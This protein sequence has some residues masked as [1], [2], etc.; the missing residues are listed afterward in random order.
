MIIAAFAALFL[1]LWAIF[2]ATLPALR[3]LGRGL[4][5]YAA[6]NT[7]VERVFSGAEKRFRVYVPVVV[8]VVAGV[9]LTAWAGDLFLDLALQVHAKS[10]SLEQTD[11]HIHDWAVTRRS[12]GATRFFVIMTVLGGPVGLAVLITAV[13]AL[14]AVRHRYRWLL[15]LLVTEVGGALLNLG[16]KQYFARSRPDVAEMLRRAHGYSFPSGHAMGSAVAFS[17]LAYLAMRSVR[18]WPLKAAILS[19]ALSMM[20]AVALSRVY[21]G[22]H[23]LSDVAAGVIAGLVWVSSTTIAY[24]TLRRIRILR[25]LRRRSATA[26]AITVP[27]AA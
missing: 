12:G 23:W 16:L 15:Y 24:E 14:L 8:I 18:S 7:R 26:A 13:S 25:A 4:A 2:Y 20:T 22:V 11:A 17:A 6:R 10:N 5:S 27:P 3:H 19:L 1:I 9:L 21:L